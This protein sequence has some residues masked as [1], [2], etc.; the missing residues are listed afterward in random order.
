M[1]STEVTTQ[2]AAGW[3]ALSATDRHL[4]VQGSSDVV[5]DLQGPLEAGL[6]EVL[7]AVGR[8]GLGGLPDFALVDTSGEVT[9]ILVR[10]T[11]FVRADG[12]QVSSESRMPWRDVDLDAAAIELG[13]GVKGGW[14]RPKRLGRPAVAAVVEAEGEAEQ[15]PEPE[16]EPRQPEPEPEPEPEP[17]LQPESDEV[18]VEAEPEPEPV[19]AEAEPEAEIE[20]EPEVELS[21]AALAPPV[22]PA[23]LTLPPSEEYAGAA[24]A[25]RVA[26]AKAAEPGKK[27]LIDS[28]PW[29]TLPEGDRPAPAADSAPAPVAD[30]AP[31][32]VAEPEPA[33]VDGPTGPDNWGM[34]G[35]PPTQPPPTEELNSEPPAGPAPEPVVAPPVPDVT[36]DRSAL[37]PGTEGPADSPVV[38]A[39]ICPAGHH[40][41]PHASACRVCGRDIPTQ[42]PFQ[43]PR[44]Q[45]G[46]LAVS[47][48]GVVPL[49]RGILLGRAPK[50]NADLPPSSRPHLVRL[51]SADNDISRNHAEIILEGW[52]VL[53]RDLGSTNGTTVTLPGQEPVRLRPTEDFGIEP[54]AILTLADEVSLTYEVSE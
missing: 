17:A 25:D 22:P 45:L 28:V 20:A 54:G 31:A 19:E 36:M 1:S 44:P 21:P 40:S 23:D 16:P 34:T 12:S 51:A 11:A 8:E 2:P 27:V 18:E 47:T 48:G 42:Q 24:P 50:V 52:H 30:P 29:R 15:V 10:G 49:D 46:T 4:I 35:P 37:T 5:D 26:P 3:V 38:L 33:A 32:P 7:E 9:R 53:V 13:D 39:V 41:S 43:T 6:V 14:R